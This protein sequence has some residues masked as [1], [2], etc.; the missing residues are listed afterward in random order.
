MVDHALDLAMKFQFSCS[1]LE[2]SS[3]IREGAFSGMP[4]K[5]TCVKSMKDKQVVIL[6]L[7]L[8]IDKVDKERKR[9]R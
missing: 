9:E 1:N 7:P 2:Y 6:R 3:K 4:T 5:K 8:T